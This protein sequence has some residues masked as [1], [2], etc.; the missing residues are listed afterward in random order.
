MECIVTDGNSIIEL[1][2]QVL[3]HGKTMNSKLRK[4]V[5]KR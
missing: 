5:N 1:S 4:N 2:V 3:V